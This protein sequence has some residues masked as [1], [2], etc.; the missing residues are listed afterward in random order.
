M[1]SLQKYF[2]LIFLKGGLSN[3]FSVSFVNLQQEGQPRCISTSHSY[4]KFK[5]MRTIRVKI[6][7]LT[8]K[9]S[10]KV[11]NE[12]PPLSNGQNQSK[13]RTDITTSVH[14]VNMSVLK[15]MDEGVARGREC[16]AARRDGVST[17]RISVE[18]NLF[19]TIRNLAHLTI[20]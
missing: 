2:V 4:A 16:E 8:Y 13:Y 9:S 19:W 11:W 10:F 5:N 15:E 14:F 12:F 1:S 20:N 6:F 3:V 18:P 7:F 17:N